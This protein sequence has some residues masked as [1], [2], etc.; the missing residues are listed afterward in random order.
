MESHAKYPERKKRRDTRGEEDT[1]DTDTEDT[2][3]TDT[4]TEM[5]RKEFATNMESVLKI[6]TNPTAQIGSLVKTKKIFAE[7]RRKS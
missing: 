3:D 5:N 4:D 6:L 7:T 2:E 1:E